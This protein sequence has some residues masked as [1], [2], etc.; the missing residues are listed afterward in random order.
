[1]VQRICRRLA[2][3][4]ANRTTRKV[5]RQIYKSSSSAIRQKASCLG[6]ELAEG[7]NGRIFV[8][9]GSAG[10][11][12]FDIEIRRAAERIIGGSFVLFGEWFD[13]PR[14]ITVEDE[15]RTDFVAGYRFPDRPYDAI[16]PESGVADIKVP[17]EYGRMQYLLP[18]AAA[19]R[20]TGDARFLDCY[21]AKVG[22]FASVNPMGRGVQW[23]CTMEVGIRVFNLLSSYELCGAGFARTTQCI[24]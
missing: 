23:T 24:R 4:V 22:S 7:F 10:F 11:K 3:A 9:S 12:S 18:L 20:Q 2:V 5:K 8:D 16:K 13:L 19:F 1:M 14:D 17:W 15:W 6:N 21:R